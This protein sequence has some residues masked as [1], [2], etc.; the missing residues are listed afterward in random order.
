MEEEV[1]TNFGKYNL[2]TYEEPEYKLK[3]K[4]FP[5]YDGVIPQMNQRYISYNKELANLDKVIC[6]PTRLESTSAVFSYGHDLFY[7][8]INPESNF[9]RLHESFKSGMFLTT[10]GVLVMML[11]TAHTYIKSTET[12]ETFNLR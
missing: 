3:S 2:S 11:L 10:L 5:P 12:K 4:E 6:F 7:A 8:R 1:V 9:D